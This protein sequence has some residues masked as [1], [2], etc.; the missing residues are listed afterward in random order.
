LT[1]VSPASTAELDVALGSDG[2][3][4]SARRS[5]V[6]DATKSRFAEDEG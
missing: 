1:T 3:A 4:G 5:A 6:D 2:G